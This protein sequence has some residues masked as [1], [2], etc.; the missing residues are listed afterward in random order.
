KL[1]PIDPPM[2]SHSSNGEFEKFEGAKPTPCLRP[3]MNPLTWAISSP[4]ALYRMNGPGMGPR[5]SKANAAGFCGAEDGLGNARP[6]P[7][8]A[9]AGEPICCAATKQT[10]TEQQ[11]SIPMWRNKE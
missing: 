6:A 11:A 4:L 7:P 2:S 8:N 1:I 5:L 10:V 9:G 3:E